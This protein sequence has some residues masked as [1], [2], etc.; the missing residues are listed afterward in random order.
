MADDILRA[1]AATVSIAPP[2][3][4]DLV[5]FLR[6]SEP[7]QGDGQRLEANAVVLDDG[8]R[9]IAL[10]GLDVLGTP[11]DFGHRIRAAV[12]AAAGCSPGSVLVNSQHTHA[13]PPPAGMPKIGGD[14]EV[15]EL[16]AGWAEALVERAAEAAA[17]AAR[18]LRPALLGCARTTVEGISVNR[19][20]RV[21][22]GTI[23]GWN[24]DEAC[25]RDVA[26][27]RLDAVDGGTIATVVAFACHPVVV[28]PEVAQASSDF[29]G[30]LRERVRAWT[31]GD[32]L[33][34]QGCAGNVLPLEAFLETAGA[35]R[36]FG[37]RLALAALSA[38]ALAGDE[39][40]G[41]AR[42]AAY[43]SAVPIARWRRSREGAASVT[44]AAAERQV[45]IPLLDPPTPEQIGELRSELEAKVR[46]LQ[47]QGAPRTAWNPV[48]LHVG[49]ARRVQQRIAGGDVP[50]AVPA[51][52]QAL[53]I[54]PAALTAWPCEPFCELGLRVKEQSPAPFPIALGYSNDLVGYVATAAEHPFGGY[55]PSLAQRHF[56]QPA[57]FAPEAGDVLVDAALQ[58]SGE[59]GPW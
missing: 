8:R 52:V 9:R 53:R 14:A 49:W 31:G 46:E 36:A 50:A 18:R 2:A 5:G 39:I 37:D 21:E 13:A 19:R 4:V 35:E 30:P 27:L 41:E 22:G 47:A 59:L 12:A 34:L 15:S 43:A 32:C 25:D 26:V 24:P 58:L 17:T 33:F 57:P 3:G 42:Q 1:G 20:Q 10:V 28:G 23:L 55:E 51:P 56:D 6:R 29:V 45:A 7:S 54:G 16:E 44:I 40:R 38:H 11:G 48:L